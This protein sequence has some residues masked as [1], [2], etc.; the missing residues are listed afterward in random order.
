M[1]DA[2]SPPDRVFLTPGGGL[3]SGNYPR[4]ELVPYVREDLTGW[5]D[6]ESAPKGGF[7]E[8]SVGNKGGSRRVH[9]PVKIVAQDSEGKATI[10]YWVEAED[11]WCM[12]TKDVPPRAWMPARTAPEVR[13]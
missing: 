6:I 13:A 9:D 5:R 7:R 11:R 8:V 2:T 12:F 4:D 10:S 3:P 1:A